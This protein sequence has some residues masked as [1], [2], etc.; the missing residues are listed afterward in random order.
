MTETSI[1]IETNYGIATLVREWACSMIYN[2]KQ[3]HLDIS[4]SV[5]PLEEM[6]NFKYLGA[7][8]SNEGSSP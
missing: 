7:I 3:Q 5:V 1:T 4:H 2:K 6:E 8:F